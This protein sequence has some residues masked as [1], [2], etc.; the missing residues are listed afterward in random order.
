[1][2]ETLEPPRDLSQAVEDLVRSLM[3]IT[4]ATRPRRN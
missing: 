2:I 4:D 3:L 1:M